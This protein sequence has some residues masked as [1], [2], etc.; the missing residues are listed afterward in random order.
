MAELGGNQMISLVTHPILENL[1]KFKIVFLF[2]KYKYKKIIEYI[3]TCYL[4]I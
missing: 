1:L 3:L 4:F 2:S